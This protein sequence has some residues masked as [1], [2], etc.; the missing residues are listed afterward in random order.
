MQNLALQCRAIFL[1]ENMENDK[2][3][4][5]V[6]SYT[7]NNYYEYKIKL[8]CD[9]KI[10]ETALLFNKSH[11]MHLS[12]LEKLRDI[13]NPSEISSRELC[14][15]IL[16]RDI[17]YSDITD[18]DFW[19]T[20]LNDPQTNNVTYTIEDRIE[21]LTNFRD[22]LNNC[23]VK[24]Y[25]WNPDCH[26]SYR[27]YSSEIKADF[28]LVFESDNPKTSDERVYA[29][30]KLDKNN[31]NIAHGIS[32]F[33]TDRTYNDDGRRSVP[34]IKIISFIEHNKVNNVDRVIFELS[35]DERQRL[36]EK[37]LKNSEYATIKLDLKQL[38]S[39]RT[40]YLEADTPTAKA[41]YE[42][43]LAIFCNKNIYSA[44]MLKSVAE[45]LAAQEKDPNNKQAKDLISKELDYIRTE[46]SN[47]ERT[48]NSELSS[49]ITLT[50]SVFH[51]D[52][53]V[54]MTEP[55]ATLKVPQVL[56]KSKSAI[57]RAAHL[58]AVSAADIVSNIKNSF[59]KPNK[60][61]PTKKPIKRQTVNSKPKT[62]QS[63]KPKMPV[64]ENEQEKEP[65]FS[66]AEVKSDKY[67]PTSNQDKDIGMTKKNDLE[68]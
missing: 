55:I 4:D 60:K 17:T 23:S 9:G 68:L 37:S 61:T 28:M 39:K 57:K 66:I 2:L 41:A 11:F 32:Q 13:I 8:Y 19:G 44:D 10:N 5:C 24:A 63:V 58:V 22:I 35:P 54:S 42:K 67:A 49:G 29:F 43:R 36:F 34:E 40:K 12:G 25:S 31:P 33:P 27:P 38:K 51:K 50:K 30:F 21:T 48:H 62:V 6:L 15:K 45:R 1:G 65:L 3:Y 64:Q 16:N 46:I 14:D 47:R 20:A 53:T 26:S 59:S 56:I 7:Q 18:S 52:G